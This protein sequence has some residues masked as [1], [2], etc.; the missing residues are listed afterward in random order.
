MRHTSAFAVLTLSAALLALTTAPAAA[1]KDSVPI[2]KAPEAFHEELVLKPMNDGSV[3][4]HF[5]FT[6]H[7]GTMMDEQHLDGAASNLC[8]AT[9]R[10]LLIADL[11]VELLMGSCR[12]TSLIVT[13]NL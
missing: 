6:T 7:L 13:N 4:S 12:E 5:Q 9:V 8:K 10:M 3:Y 11:T 2:L 1:A